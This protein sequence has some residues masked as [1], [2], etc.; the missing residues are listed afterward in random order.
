MASNHHSCRLCSV[1][2]SLFSTLGIQQKWSCRISSLLEI[3]V[4]KNDGLSAYICYQCKNRIVHLEK[5][6][7][8]LS[9]F[10]ALAKSSSCATGNLKHC[11]VT[12]AE[13][14]VSPDTLRQ[15]PHSKMQRRRL[16]F[17]GKVTRHVYNYTM[18]LQQLKNQLKQGLWKI[19]CHRLLHQVLFHRPLCLNILTYI[20]I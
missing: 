9:A 5:S 6:L 19:L 12:S 1:N 3:T 20:I 17:E 16:E 18:N 10:K 8:D 14:G 11:K 4:D 13:V 2:N 7:A 15:R